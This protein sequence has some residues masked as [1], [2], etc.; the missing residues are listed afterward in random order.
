M[1]NSTFPINQSSIPQ[2]FSYAEP[3][4]TPFH[5]SSNLFWIL[6]VIS[7]LLIIGLVIYIVWFYNKITNKMKE[8]MDL[9][10]KYKNKP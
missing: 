9:L 2:Q 3:A 1:N 5:K 4:N 7:L 8:E 10:N 6:L